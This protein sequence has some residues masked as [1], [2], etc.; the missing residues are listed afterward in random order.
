MNRTLTPLATMVIFVATL[1]AILG[2]RVTAATHNPDAADGKKIYSSKC[3][4]CHK[5][6]GSGGVKL[7]G[8]PT[9]DWRNPK[10]MS[11][12]AHS[13]SALRD[14]IINGKPKSGMV[15]WVKSDQL[16]PAQVEN[17]IAYIHMFSKKK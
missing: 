7:T 5:A 6:D 2:F 16:K 14:C 15:A 3:V 10:L 13:D 4:V 9:P 12:P 17:L 11:A 8:N 1:C